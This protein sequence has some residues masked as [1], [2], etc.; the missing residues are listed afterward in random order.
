MTNPDECAEAA[1]KLEEAQARIKLAIKPIQSA[2]RVPLKQLLGRVLAEDIYAQSDLP[3][4]N[5]SAMDGYA[6][7]GIDSNSFRCVGKSLTGAPYLNKLAP[8]ECVYISTGAVVPDETQAVV[9]QEH[10]LAENEFI[11]PTRTIK[12]NQNIRFQG[13]EIK[14][15]EKLIDKSKRLSPADIG[16]LASNG[17]YDVAV[18]RKLRVAFFSTGSELKTVGQSLKVGEIYDSNRYLLDALLQGCGV[19]VFDLGVVKD[20]KQALKH[21]IEQASAMADVVMTTGGA[22]VSEVDFIAEILNETGQVDFWKVA[23]KPGKPIAF[24][25]IN[26]AYFFGLPGNPVSVMVT[27]EKI[28]RPALF[29]LMGNEMTKALSIQ[30]VCKSNLKKSPGRIEFQRGI[31]SQEANGFSVTSCGNQGS[32]LLRS[33]SK[34][35]CFIVLPVESAGVKPGDMVYVEPLTF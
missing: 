25:L 18:I 29:Q 26:D 1:L 13:E 19:E 16:L 24:G 23:M 20:D 33:S 4:F 31:L 6:V 8:G 15:G 28:V 10:V 17:L 34:A 7:N 12:P 22:S 32:H 2:E 9:M 11:M 21:M 5:N 27:F 30:A 14:S 3:L 35:N